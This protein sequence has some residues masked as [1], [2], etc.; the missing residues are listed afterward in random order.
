[1]QYYCG[2]TVCSK[3][4]RSCRMRCPANQP[5][6]TYQELLQ[7]RDEV[8]RWSQSVDK[9]WGLRR[10]TANSIFL[11]DSEHSSRQLLSVECQVQTHLFYLLTICSSIMSSQKDLSDIYRRMMRHHPFGYALY[12]PLLRSS[13]KPGSCGILHRGSW[14]ELFHLNDPSSLSKNLLS[15]AEDTSER[16]VE[17][18]LIWDPKVSRGAKK[19]D[20]GS[21]LTLS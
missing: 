1:M 21:D 7:A 2:V 18:G 20:I 11:P 19:I 13:V 15:V 3:I 14:T 5:Y 6:T 16:L 4:M 12:K 9:M 17:K 10:A 8:P